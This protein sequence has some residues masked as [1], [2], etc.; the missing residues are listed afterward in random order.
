MEKQT[1]VEV[2]LETASEQ[3]IPDKCALEVHCALEAASDQT[4]SGLK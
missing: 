3:T 1:Q 2:A 4:S